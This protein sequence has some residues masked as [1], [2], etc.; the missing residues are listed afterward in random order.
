MTR[1]VVTD[2]K[3][4]IVKVEDDGAPVPVPATITALQARLALQIA[5]ELDAVEAFVNEAGGAAKI[6]WEYATVIERNSPLV[7]GAAEALGMTGE[8]M[9]DLFRSA[10]AL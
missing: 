3:G 9:D 2:G 4:R 1:T 10:A 8:Q 5:G 7:E 6:V